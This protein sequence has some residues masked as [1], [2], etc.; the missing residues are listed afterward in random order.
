[1]GPGSP[2]LGTPQ[3]DGAERGVGGTAVGSAAEMQGEEGGEGEKEGNS[4]EDESQRALKKD[5]EKAPSSA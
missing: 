4:F 2:S 3:E 5:Q 1:M